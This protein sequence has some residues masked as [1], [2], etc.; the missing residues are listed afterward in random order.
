MR[1][2]REQFLQLQGQLIWLHLMIAL[3]ILVNTLM[4]HLRFWDYDFML[5]W[6]VISVAAV[7]VHDDLCMI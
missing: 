6:D 2:I 1:T 3:K 7:Y 4:M 5:F